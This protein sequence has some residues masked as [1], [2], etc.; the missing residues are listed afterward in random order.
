MYIPPL[1]PELG[2]AAQESGLDLGGG[3][4]GLSIAL[5]IVSLLLFTF[6]TSM[7][8]AVLAVSR[9]RIKHLAAEGNRAARARNNVN[10][11]KRGI[12][13]QP[14]LGACMDGDDF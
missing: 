5:L 11:A 13:Y 4:L 3:G 6:F 2:V 9:V 8:A 7:E 12:G 14:Q 10:M 1:R